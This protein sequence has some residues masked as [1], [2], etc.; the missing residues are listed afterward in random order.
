M[1]FVL[2]NLR[3]ATVII[4]LNQTKVVENGALSARFT[5]NRIVS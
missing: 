4:E 2:I 1:Y 5:K 3:F